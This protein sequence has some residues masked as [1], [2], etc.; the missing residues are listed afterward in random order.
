MK[1]DYD[2]DKRSC[3]WKNYSF[4][5]LGTLMY[6][7]VALYYKIKYKVDFGSWKKYDE[8]I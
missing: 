4:F 2:Y 5:C 8:L 3:C 7:S 1:E 6:I